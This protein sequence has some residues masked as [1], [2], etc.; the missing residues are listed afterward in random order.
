MRADG[1]NVLLAARRSTKSFA[2]TSLQVGELDRLL[3][4]VF[5]VAPDG[6][7]SYGSA[8]ARYPVTATVVVGDVRGLASGSYRITGSGGLQEPE[9]GDQRELIAQS[10]IDAHWAASCPALLVLSANVGA[11][12]AEFASQAEGRGERFI[13]IEVGLIAQTVH[14]VAAG[15]DLGTVL[16]AGVQDEAA[17]RLPESIVPPGDELLAVMPLGRATRDSTA[18]SG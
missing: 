18:A 13:A 2:A 15:L 12:R 11:E 16:I 7:R 8:H 6:R 14:L 4:A 17:R 5:G 9:Y 10:T 1:L 3:S